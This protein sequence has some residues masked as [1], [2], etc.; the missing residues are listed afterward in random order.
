MN[1][2]VSRETKERDVLG[3][4]NWRSVAE[5]LA[6]APV[7]EIFEQDGELGDERAR[8][9]SELWYSTGCFDVEREEAINSRKGGEQDVVL[10]W[11]GEALVKREVLQSATRVRH[12]KRVAREQLPHLREENL[13]RREANSKGDSSVDAERLYEPDIEPRRV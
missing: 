11:D 2:D 13:R 6:V 9:F 8:Q 7:T 10:E 4:C 3:K 12:Q 5:E 1:E